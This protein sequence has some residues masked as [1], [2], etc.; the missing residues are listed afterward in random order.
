M[1]CCPIITTADKCE[2]HACFIFCIKLGKSADET[3]SQAFDKR[4][5]CG[6]H[7]FE[8]NVVFKT[9]QV[10]FQGDERSERT[11]TERKKNMNKIWR[12]D[13]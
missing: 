1:D 7:V 10:P 5:S 3:L 13:P 8:W 9:D 2:Q 4:P 11:I 12:T 6:R